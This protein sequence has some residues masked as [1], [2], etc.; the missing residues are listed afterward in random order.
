[1]FHRRSRP[2]FLASKSPGDCLVVLLHGCTWGSGRRR[3][4]LAPVLAAV[5]ES[6][7]AA[8]ILLPFMPIEFWSLDDADEI[9]ED[10]MA[11][12][13]DVWN[14]QT[15]AGR[16]Y[17]RVV[18]IGFSFGSVL[19]RQV[20]CRAAGARADASIDAASARQW[21][22]QVERLILLAGLNRGWTV[23]SPV[24]R[25]ESF[26][27][28]I[29]TAIGHL[30]PRKPTLFAI[31]RGAPFLTRTRLQWLALEREALT[32]PLTVQLLGTRD[33]IV[34]PV[35]NIDLA[36]GGRFVYL[37]VPESGHFDVIQM[38]GPSP[39]T[40]RRR[41]EF[42]RALLDSPEDL[43]A[44]GI[45]E[46]ELLQLLPLAADPTGESA[47]RATGGQPFDDL[48]FVVHGIRDKGF[49]TRKLARVV[50]AHG[51]AQG[52]N[53]IAVAPTYGY[54]PMLPFLLPWTRRAKVEWLLDIYVSVKCWYPTAAVS[55]I[56]HSN[57]TFIVVGAIE[58]CPAVKFKN[59]VFAGSV[60]PTRFNWKRFL[61]ADATEACANQVSKVVNYVAA[62]D[63]VVA[64]FP[65]F[66][67]VVGL[68]D[69][70]SA[71]H[72]GF[73]DEPKDRITD[74]E[75]VPGRHSAALD[76]ENWQEI[77]NFIIDGTLPRTRRG[78]RS[79]WVTAFGH[80]TPLIWAF[81]ATVALFPIYL[82]LTA[83]GVPEMTGL[84]WV[85]TWRAQVAPQLPAW[86][87][88]GGL[89]GWMRFVGLVLTRL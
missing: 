33:D 12:I 58:A 42:Q 44:R 43:R 26:F 81:L 77:A 32:P 54:F 25:I 1:M 23:D 48:V 31:R 35:D 13:D 50:V 4:Q 17:R 3:T 20:F 9:A 39:V 85:E 66:F 60:V 67:Q 68:P 64:I 36:T 88:A 84:S 51:R 34:S 5:R 63:W 8:D 41:L 37:E 53:V 6:L 2:V 21:A 65:K 69:L 49:W 86:L 79:V 83:L 29:G 74:V 30:L 80:V 16:T 52:R 7:P 47:L 72:D 78:N 28:N 56:G 87:L 70:G 62:A 15:C 18:M 38:A 82:F 40:A 59:L 57:G 76:E 89:L 71:G 27:N 14:R 11:E 55:F 46:R 10:V 24:T 45:P 61:D 73:V 22:Q 19:L 75:Y